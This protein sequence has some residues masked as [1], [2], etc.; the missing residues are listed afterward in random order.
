MP[1]PSMARF[2][3]RFE[4]NS[5]GNVA[6]AVR[7]QLA[8]AGLK[9]AIAPGARIAVTGGSRGIDEIDL[10]TRTVIDCIREC[11]GKM[12]MRA[13]EWSRAQTD[14]FEAFK[15]Y[16]EAGDRRRRRNRGR[17]QAGL[18]PTADTFCQMEKVKK[19]Y[20]M[21]KQSGLLSAQN[22]SCLH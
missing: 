16:D 1:F 19:L 11:G 13:H 4:V 7:E 8:A 21:D 9:E 15:S 5:I 14:F 18:S 12:H 2:R 6:G 3:Q 22:I 17:S 20:I 10:I